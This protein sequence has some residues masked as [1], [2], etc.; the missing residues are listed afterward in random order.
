[1][2]LKPIEPGTAAHRGERDA[3]QRAQEQARS[4][5]HLW[6]NGPEHQMQAKTPAANPPRG[7]AQK[8]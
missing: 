2:A 4:Q 8:K 3:F 1:M 5:P 6:A 7:D